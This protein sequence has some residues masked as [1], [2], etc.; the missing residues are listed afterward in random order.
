M[1]TRTAGSPY[2]AVRLK[3]KEQVAEGTMAFR[4][5]KPLPSIS[6]LANRSTRPCSILPKQIQRATP[7][8]SPSR[9]SPTRHSADRDTDAGYGFQTLA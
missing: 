2:L 7:G 6:R 9:C 1:G 5:E 3:V 4:F 8:H